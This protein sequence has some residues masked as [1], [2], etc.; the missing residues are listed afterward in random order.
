MNDEIVNGMQYAET[1][2]GNSSALTPVEILSAVDVIRSRPPVPYTPPAQVV[3]IS[4]KPE[5][6]VTL[7]MKRA[8]V[9]IVFLSVVGA[10]HSVIVANSAILVA[11]VA[12]WIGGG[13]GLLCL[14]FLISCFSGGGSGETK[15]GTAGGP[16]IIN[17]YYQNNYLGN[18]SQ[19]NQV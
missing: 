1:R 8:C 4:A 13:F 5:P 15:S 3:E 12:P 2:H 18:G 7:P 14:G 6:L 17:N 19:N 16:V 10:A 11:T 9:G